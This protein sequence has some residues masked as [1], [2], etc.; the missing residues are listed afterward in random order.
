MVPRGID[1]HGRPRE[2]L[3]LLD[4]GGALRVWVNLCQHI[5]IPL[6]SGSREFWDGERRHLICLTHGATYRPRDGVC[7]AGP[8]EGERLQAVPHE[9]RDGVILLFEPPD[10]ED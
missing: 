1:A 9:V 7:T 4:A 3:V 10:P 5:P 2:A 8:C 6:D